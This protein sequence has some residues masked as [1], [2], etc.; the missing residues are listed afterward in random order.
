MVRLVADAGGAKS[1]SR[2]LS[3]VEL[4]EL[5]VGGEAAVFVLGLFGWV[6]WGIFLLK[7]KQTGTYFFKV[8]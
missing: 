3:S 7:Q 8:L 4:K 5:G 2:S 1:F 6:V